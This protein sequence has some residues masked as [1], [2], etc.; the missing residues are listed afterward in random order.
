MQRS[1]YLFL[2]AFASFLSACDEKLETSEVD[3]QRDYQ[4]LGIGYFWI[5]EVD[6][7]I[8]Y[9]ENDSETAQY[10][11]KDLIRTSYFNAENEETFIVSRSKSSD[12]QSWEL[13]LEYTMILRDRTLL[14]TLNN[15][16]LTALIFPPQVG[17]VWNGKNYLAEGDDNFEIDF[18]GRSEVPGF[19]DIQGVRVI[20]ENLDD[21]VTIRDV[22]YEF[23]GKGV[24]LIEKYDEVLTYCSRND[25]LGQELIN[26]G[27]KIHLKLVENG[28]E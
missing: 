23:F 11:Y 4:P 16:T 5:Y 6:E 3:L 2:I 24:G 14:R 9:G 19:E 22:R 27:S 7:T 12:R 8:Y 13:E 28:R 17:K 10:Y 15:T 1:L 18:T 26:S 25:C 20:Q 21:K